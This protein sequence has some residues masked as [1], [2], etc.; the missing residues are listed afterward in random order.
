MG[1][2]AEMIKCSCGGV[3][4]ETTENVI[5]TDKQGIQ[6]IIKNVP[7]SKCYECEEDSCPS[8][9]QISV[10]WLADEMRKGNIPSIVEYKSIF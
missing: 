2:V 5:W 7:V 8:N 1:A 10:S 6:Y 9:V 4:H 3:I